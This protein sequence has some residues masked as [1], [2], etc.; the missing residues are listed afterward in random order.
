MVAEGREE[1]KRTYKPF[2]LQKR[3]F[4]YTL[5]SGEVVIV[6]PHKRLVE[7]P[8]GTTVKVVKITIDTRAKDVDNS[9]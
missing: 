4:H 2:N 3:E 7:L 6:T 5:P 9:K 1:P 8:D